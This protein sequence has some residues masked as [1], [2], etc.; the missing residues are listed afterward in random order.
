MN[1][2]YDLFDIKLFEEKENQMKLYVSFLLY[3]FLFLS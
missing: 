2:E 3:Y 1:D